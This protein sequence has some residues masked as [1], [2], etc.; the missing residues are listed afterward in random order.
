MT[1]FSWITALSG[2]VGV[3]LGAFLNAYLKYRSERKTARQQLLGQIGKFSEEAIAAI[4]EI[5]AVILAGAPVAEKWK[6]RAEFQRQNAIGAT[7]EM[8]IFREFRSRR[9]RAGFHKVLSRIDAFKEFV[10][11][12]KVISEKEFTLGES[13]IQKQVSDTI[14]YAAGPAGVSLVDKKRLLFVGF[15]RLTRQDI[16]PYQCEDRPPPWKFHFAIEIEDMDEEGKRLCSAANRPTVENLRCA[17]H[18]RPAHVMFYGK[19]Q[20]NFSIEVDAC[21]KE[22]IEK[23]RSKLEP[24]S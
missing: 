5:Y 11:S 10:D 19:T 18:G 13:W 16:D 22:F 2:F 9:V 21:C 1:G 20:R 17:T 4:A 7:L 6:A 15:K 14:S 8:Q 24:R 23:V 12:E 3:L